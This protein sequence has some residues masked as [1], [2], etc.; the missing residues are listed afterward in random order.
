MTEKI[1][2]Y[3][4][5]S[6]ECINVKAIVPPSTFCNKTDSCVLRVGYGFTDMKTSQT[7]ADKS[8]VPQAL[9]EKPASGSSC[10]VEISDDNWMKEMCIYI[11][12]VA[13][14]LKDKNKKLHVSLT[15]RVETT[16]VIQETN[17]SSIEVQ[18]PWKRNITVAKIFL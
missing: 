10:W 15:V 12:A 18:F 5:F 14:G 7:C 1:K 16:V 6:G 11:R 4:G 9:F 2:I 8:I 17:Y 3:E 13:D